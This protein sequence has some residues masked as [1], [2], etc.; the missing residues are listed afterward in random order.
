MI[1]FL[2]GDMY[3][4]V[5]NPRV[6]GKAYNAFL[7]EFIRQ[8]KPMRSVIIR[9]ISRSALDAARRGKQISLA[10]HPTELVPARKVVIPILVALVCSM[11]ENADKGVIADE[12]HRL[13][14]LWPDG[15]PPRAALKRVNDVL[16][17]NNQ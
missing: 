13:V 9:P 5:P 16:M 11:R 10:V 6:D 7:T 1:S 4:Y 17:S 12:L 3:C 15:N 2:K 8:A 14:S